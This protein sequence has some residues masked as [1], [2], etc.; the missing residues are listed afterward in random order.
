MSTLQYYLAR[1]NNLTLHA[2]SKY[3]QILAVQSIWQRGSAAQI[4]EPTDEPPLTDPPVP[5]PTHDPDETPPTYD[6]LVDS[7]PHIELI[8]RGEL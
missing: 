8:K 1:P 5:K 4:G 3:K 2:R 7:A 6:A